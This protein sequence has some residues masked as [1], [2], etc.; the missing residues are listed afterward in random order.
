MYLS[1]KSIASTHMV[2]VMFLNLAQQALRST[3]LILGTVLFAD[4]AFFGAHY[5]AVGLHLG[6]DARE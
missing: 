6:Q 2:G 5:V 3:K 1:T 4:E